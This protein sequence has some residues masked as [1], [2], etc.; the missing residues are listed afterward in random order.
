MDTCTSDRFE[1]LEDNSHGECLHNESS[2]LITMPGGLKTPQTVVKMYFF[3]FYN[4][5]L[6]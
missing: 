4:S 6:V 5:S 1:C 3:L 2:V